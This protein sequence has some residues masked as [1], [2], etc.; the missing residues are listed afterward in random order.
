M[1]N[2]D[3]VSA[4][5][6]IKQFD[7]TKIIAMTSCIRSDD[8]Q[9]YF[10]YGMEDC[11]PKPFTKEGLLHMLQENLPDLVANNVMK[12]VASAPLPEVDMATSSQDVPMSSRP[13]GTESYPL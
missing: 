10:R 12:P 9:M 3:G 7:S 2:L 13:A 4:C 6:L 8:I 11:L 5:H 1:P